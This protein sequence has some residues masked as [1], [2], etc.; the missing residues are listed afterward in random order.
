[1]TP[2][3]PGARPSE[4]RHRLLTTATRIFYSEG[5]HSVG[6]DRIIAE[7]KVTRA[8]FYRHFPSKDD[9]ILAYLRE[10]HQMERGTIDAAIAT[11]SSPAG[12]LLAIAGSIAQN[13]QSPGFRGCAFLN[14]AAEY[15]DTEHPVRQEIIAHRQ[16][17][18][19]TLSMLMAQVHQETA[20]PAAR[21]FVMLRDG[22]MAAGCLFD[23]ALVSETFLR[24]VEGLLLINAERQSTESAG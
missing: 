17:F 24:G 1:M 18:L 19:D 6:V 12:S 16:W 5:I 22:A 23:P 10:V 2:T 20:D 7:A 4:A 13:I 15:P 8:T 9:L 14:A 3:A 21:H 11:D